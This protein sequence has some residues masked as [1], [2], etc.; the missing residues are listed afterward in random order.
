MH[1]TYWTM[2]NHLKTNFSK[3]KTPKCQRRGVWIVSWN[4]F[5]MKVLLNKEVY[6]SCEQYTEPTV[7]GI[8][9]NHLK[10]DFP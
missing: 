7:Q 1:G 8:N 3:K 4:P 6:R 9:H 5:L 2:H 10:I